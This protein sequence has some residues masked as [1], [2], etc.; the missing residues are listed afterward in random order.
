[1]IGPIL[2]PYS[3]TNN[4]DTVDAVKVNSNYDVVYSGANDVITEL[5]TA[6]GTRTSLTDFLS[7]SHNTDGSI[8]SGSL[9]DGTFDVRQV[10]TEDADYTVVDGNSVIMVATTAADIT[11]TLPD[12]STALQ[13]VKVVKTTADA[14]TVIIAPSGS[15]TIM[16]GT[17]YVITLQ[18]ESAEIV[19]LGT[20]WWVI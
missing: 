11:V 12:A 6:S 2:K 13:R 7:I 10:Q 15:D 16:E 17:Q 1:M 3:F 9:P 14:N 4:V 8:K 19:P 18:G 5:N 20:N